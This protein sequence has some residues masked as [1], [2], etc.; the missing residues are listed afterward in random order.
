MID[1]NKVQTTMQR[2]SIKRRAVLAWD[3]QEARE[4]NTT[5]YYRR[6]SGAPYNTNRWHKLAKAFI[7]DH[8]LCEECK[9]KGII[10]A[11][12]CVDHIDPWPICKDY[13]FDRRNLQALCNNCNNLKGQRDKL[14]IQEWRRNHPDLEGGFNLSGLTH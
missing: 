3:T 4:R 12:E 5:K 6:P 11:A 10:R 13:F 1:K 2:T 9:R 14:K 8:P 7:E